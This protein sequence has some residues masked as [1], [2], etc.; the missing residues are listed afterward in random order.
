MALVSSYDYRLVALSILISLLASYTAL[1]V[2]GRVSSAKGMGRTLW[3]GCGVLAM[4][5]G[6]WSM[7]YVGM[8][9]LRLPIPVRYDWPTVLV[10][11]LAAVLASA[12]MFFVVSRKKMGFVLAI[13]GSIFMG[14]GIAAMHY[15][16]MAAMRLPAVCH[17]SKLIVAASIVLAILASLVALSLGFRV[18]GETA[19]GD[20]RKTLGALVMGLAIPAMHYTGMAAASFTGPAPVRGNMSHAWSISTLGIVGIVAV[21]LVLLGFTVITALLDRRFSAEVEQSQSLLALLLESAPE[22]I[23]GI[24]THGSCTFCNQAFL[25][26]TGYE[27]FADLQGRNVH[28]VIHHTRPDGS[29]YPVKECHIYEAFRLG[30]GTHVDDEVLWRKDGSSF[31]AEYWSRPLRRAGEIVGSVVTF[32]DVTERKRIEEVLRDARDAA[33]AANNAK[34]AFLMIMSHELRT[35]MNGI[36]GM[37]ELVLDSQLTAEQREY[38]GMVQSSAESLLSM[39]NDILDFAQ[40][41]GGT[42]KLES[43]PFALRE[44]LGETIKALDVQAQQKSLELRWEVRPDVPETVVGDLGRIRQILKILIG[45]AIKFTKEGGVSITVDEDSHE[46]T[47]CCLHFTVKDTGIGI[48]E[49]MKEKIFEPFSQADESVTRNY[50]GTGMGLSICSKLATAMGGKIWVE[51]EPGTGSTFHFTVRVPSQRSTCS[52]S[53][54]R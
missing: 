35:P 54:D 16:G 8:L 4:G 11:L 37:T 28:D 12:I 44:S 24:D 13:V 40:I 10:S 42:L 49:D 2:A 19:T 32:L 52:A 17:Y 3:L 1:E 38:L 43:M 51:S 22:S 6:I 34:S 18:P 45:N 48:A 41:E 27:S 14:G 21:T 23:Y 30:K 29:P 46:D 9:A 5:V 53:S 26:M 20:R 50:G 7:H 31:P 47:H 39:I 15:I 36:F 25:Q 33:E